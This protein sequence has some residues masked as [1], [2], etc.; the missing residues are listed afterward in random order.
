MLSFIKQPFFATKVDI[1]GRLRH[2]SFF[3]DGV[4]RSG[5]IAVLAKNG[6]SRIKNTA[7]FLRGLWAESNR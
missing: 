7:F 3:S 1:Q 2:L 4:K 5:R 6:P